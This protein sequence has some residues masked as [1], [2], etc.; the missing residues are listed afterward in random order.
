M[1]ATR[2]VLRYHGGKWRLA[3]WI[4]TYL[5][6]H[7]HYTEAYCGGASVLLRKPR[8]AA[9]LIND[10]DGDVV[11]LFRVL[12]D[13]VAAR[14]LERSIRLTPFARDEFEDAYG[15]TDEPV[16]QARRLIVRSAMGFG[17][18]AHNPERRTGFRWKAWRQGTA[19]PRDFAAYPAHLAAVTARLKDV[20]IENRDALEVLTGWDDPRT[21]HYVDPPYPHSTRH[22]ATGTNNAYRHEMSDDDHRAL[23]TTLRDLKGMVVL[24]GYACDL[25]DL[26][27]FPDWQ[28]FECQTM[29]STHNASAPATEVLWLNAAAA[30]RADQPRLLEATA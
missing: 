4:I 3:P 1:T 27:L 16:E 23:A 20:V 15:A 7:A 24:S 10:R 5:P 28:R 18:A 14:E 12:R 30:N 29:K 22:G 6:P 9:E 17:S 21:L 19:L 2:P 26:E 25:Y 11:N 13:S 8:V